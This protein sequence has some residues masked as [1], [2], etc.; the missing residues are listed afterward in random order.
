MATHQ[1]QPRY[2]NRLVKLGV[3]AAW[4]A[5]QQMSWIARWVVGKGATPPRMVVLCYHGIERDQL[6]G[7]RR[8]I[9]RLAHT[10]QVLG[11]KVIEHQLSRRMPSQRVVAVTFDDGFVNVRENALPILR[12]YDMA[13]ILFVPSGYLGKTA[14][15]L[16]TNDKPDPKRRIFSPSQLRELNTLGCQIA[17]HTATHPHLCGLNDETLMQELAGSRQTLER[18]LDQPVHLLAFPYGEYDDRVVQ[19]AEIAG[20]TMMFS[21]LPEE[22]RK[23]NRSILIG[24]IGVT[25]EDWILEFELKIRGA[26]GW[27][28]WAVRLKRALKAQFV[29]LLH[30]PAVD[31]TIAQDA[32]SIQ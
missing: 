17:S 18:V 4:F 31:K 12:S 22:P 28:P 19:M 11:P 10:A 15:W 2:G 27:V 16:K 7:F 32:R 30:R 25:P 14:R 21:G 20:Y 13:P 6:P 5:V 24:R 1:Q 26:Y 3:S 23:E 29:L 8:Q 9:R